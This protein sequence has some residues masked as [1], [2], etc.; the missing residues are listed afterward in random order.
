MFTQCPHWINSQW[1]W[2]QLVIHLGILLK[3]IVKQV[4]KEVLS[5]QTEAYN[6]LLDDPRVYHVGCLI[7]L[8][9]R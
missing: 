8:S 1:P 6:K 7:W 9:V 5:R 2:P 3:K 4:T